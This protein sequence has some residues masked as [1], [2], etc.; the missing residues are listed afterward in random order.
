MY[1]EKELFLPEIERI[2]HEKNYSFRKYSSMGV[3]GSAKVAFFPKKISEMVALINR[4]KTLDIPYRILGNTTN[5]LPCEGESK[6]VAVFTTEMNAVQMDEEGVFA[7]AGATTKSFL[8]V[9]ERYGKT[10]AEFLEGIPATVGGAVYM[11]AGAY[12]KRIDG[13]LESVLVFKDGKIRLMKK[14][15]CAYSY[16]HSVFMN[17]EYVILGATFHL[18]TCD[19]DEVSQKREYYRD[20]RK[21]LPE[22]KSLG[23][24]FKNPQSGSDKSAGSLIEGAGLK[25]LF[26]GGAFVSR[27]HANFIINGGNATTEDILSLINIIKSAVFSQYG[28]RLEEEIRYLD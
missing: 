17:D 19:I 24:I 4:L 25:G 13:V 2:R 22:G 9:C 7:A 14:E 18:E 26:S 10:G 15:N 8:E 1:K 5:S 23:C 20:L 12:G 16:K 11:N 21:K 6:R 3:G 28:V 27:E